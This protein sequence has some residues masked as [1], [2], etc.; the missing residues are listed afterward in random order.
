MEAKRLNLR[1]FAQPAYEF[2]PLYGGLTE[3]A[4][5]TGQLFQAHEAMRNIL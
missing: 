4:L 5:Q 2:T 1:S 3:P